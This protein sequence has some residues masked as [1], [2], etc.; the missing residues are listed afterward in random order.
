MVTSG[1]NDLDGNLLSPGYFYAAE[2]VEDVSLLSFSNLTFGTY[3]GGLR[4]IQIGDVDS[5][6]NPNLYIAGHYNESIYDWEYIE[7]DPLSPN[8]V[9]TIVFMD[10]TDNYTPNNDQG[11][12]RVA[13]FFRDIDND[14]NGDIVFLSGSF[15]SDKPQLFMVEYEEQSL[16]IQDNK[17]TI[18]NFRLN[19]NYPNPFNPTTKFEY[20]LNNDGEIEI[21]IYDVT[22]RQIIEL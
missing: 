6:G 17:T 20:F 15:A 2:G 5:D 1:V 16:S 8:S 4:Q 14:G 22:G 13:S 10:D 3:Q 7:G 18:K 21:S 9:E 12:V 19:Q 11:K